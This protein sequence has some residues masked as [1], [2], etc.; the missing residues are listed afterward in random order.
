[1]KSILYIWTLD[2]TRSHLLLKSAKYVHNQK[3]TY[4]TK[5][6][7]NTIYCKS[8]H[9]HFDT[10]ILYKHKSLFLKYFMLIMVLYITSNINKR[11]KIIV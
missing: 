4:Q 2:L 5:Q 11:N 3:Q 8:N 9:P 10:L 1:M 7:Y 6:N